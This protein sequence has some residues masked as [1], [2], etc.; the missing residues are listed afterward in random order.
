MTYAHKETCRVVFRCCGQVAGQRRLKRQRSRAR[1][2]SLSRVFFFL[3]KPGAT[4]ILS[5]S[6]NLSR[7]SLSGH[8]RVVWSESASNARQLL[9]PR[10]NARAHREKETSTRPYEARTLEKLFALNF[11]LLE[12]RP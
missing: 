8:W 11:S 2:R 4:A 9:P 10:A 7:D 3:H 12:S 5:A 6:F 1:A